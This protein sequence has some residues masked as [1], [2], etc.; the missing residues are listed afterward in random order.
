[1]SISVQSKITLTMGNLPNC[2][3]ISEDS[4]SSISQKSFSSR[5]IRL[6]HD[7]ITQDRVT[8]DIPNLRLTPSETIPLSIAS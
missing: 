4:Q 5:Y 6:I 3:A 2:L 8:S 1:M 7:V